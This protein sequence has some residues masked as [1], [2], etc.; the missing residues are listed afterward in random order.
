MCV[1]VDVAGFTSA[2]VVVREQLTEVGSN[3][4]ICSDLGPSSGF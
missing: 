3:L 2:Y 1:S 4:P